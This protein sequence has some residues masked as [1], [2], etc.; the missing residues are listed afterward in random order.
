MNNKEGFS[1]LELLVALT[2]VG[3]LTATAIPQ[4]A[5]Y[6][7]RGYDYRAS[8]D[9]QTVAL[10]E[11]AYFLDSERYLDCNGVSCTTLPGVQKISDGVQIV[12]TSDEDSFIGTS[13]HPKGSGKTY[14]WDSDRGGIE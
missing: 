6:K 14:R 11:E 13:T 10:A 8:T 3:V 9:L 1:L 7:R 2:I 4:Y 12:I 5:S